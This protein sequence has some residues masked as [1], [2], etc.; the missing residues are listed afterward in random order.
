[1]NAIWRSSARSLLALVTVGGIGGGGYWLYAEAR[2]PAKPTV[3]YAVVSR[4]DILNTVSATGQLEPL[5]KVEVGTQVSGVIKELHADF[6]SIVKKGQL[7]AELDPRT[8]E[9]QVLQADANV[10]RAQTDVEHDRVMLGDAN[11]KLA[12]AKD[13]FDKG[14]VNRVDYE[15]ADVDALAAQSALKSSE[16]AL[17]Q[18][19]A[20]LEQQKLNLENTRIYSPIDGIVVSR[21]VDVG[22]TVQASMQAPVLFNLAADLSEMRVLAGVDEADVGQIRPTQHVTFRIDAYPSDIFEGTVEQ[23]RLEAKMQQN[24]VT[25]QAV[26]SVPNQDL[27]LKPGM[28][29]NINIEI[30]R[31]SDVVRVPNSA[32]RFR[33][34]N[35]MYTALG[36]EP[37]AA[38]A[39]TVPGQRRPQNAEDGRSADRARERSA[40]RPDQAKV[41]ETSAR[42]AVALFAAKN[43]TTIDQLFPPLPPAESVGRVWTWDK[44]KSELTPHIVR[45]GIT[46]GQATELLDEDALEAGAQVVTNIMTQQDVRPVTA[47]GTGGNPFAQPGGRGTP[48][49]GGN[50]GFGGGRS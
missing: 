40:L 22:Q 25:Y 11:K 37:P 13:L 41:P 4:G 42:P 19:Q 26:I 29:A 47:P 44:D 5:D 31:K 49:G 17:K 10:V 8:F 34:T 30:S 18:Q 12:R 39:R 48:G 23:V 36:L 6:N 16:A 7:L 15:T 45:L 1:M 21:V 28:T 43:V 35:D 9:T 32:L 3:A 38:P 24:V 14:I 50:R 2:K 46:D 33:P 20:A 27:K